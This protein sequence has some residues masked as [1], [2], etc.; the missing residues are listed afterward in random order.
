METKIHIVYHKEVWDGESNN[1][2]PV[3]F[4]REEDALKLAKQIAD[5]VRADWANECVEET[6]T[7]FSAWRDGEYD[8]YHCEVYVSE[9]ILH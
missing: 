6:D 3:A 8:N 4:K 7:S 1:E 9:L 5:N 2:K